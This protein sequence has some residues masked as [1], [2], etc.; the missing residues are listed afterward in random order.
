MNS[1]TL[2]QKNF[3][4]S[5]KPLWSLAPVQPLTMAY[6][7]RFL[8]LNC[9]TPRSLRQLNETLRRIKK[10]YNYRSQ[11]A[12]TASY[13]KL[14]TLF[15]SLGQYDKARQ[16]QEKR[17]LSEQKLATGMEKQQVT[18]T[19]EL[20]SNHSVNMIRPENIRRNRIFNF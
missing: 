9:K 20:C 5:A 15:R 3:K 4:F 1:P 7:Y 18:S 19:Q 8:V 14:G 16:Y 6:K 12:A 11:S 13:G 2:P 10:F 17:S